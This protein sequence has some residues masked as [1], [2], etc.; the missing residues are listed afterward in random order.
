MRGPRRRLRALALVAVFALVLGACGTDDA[1][2]PDPDQTESPEESPGGEAQEP[3][4]GGTFIYARDQEPGVLNPLINDGNLV[5]TAQIALS[6]MLPLWIITPDFEYV[7]SPLLE[8]AE[9]SGEDEE[10]FSVTY[11]LN[12]D[13]VWSDGE[14]IT[15]GDVFFT[16]EICL[17]EEADITSRE[18]CNKVD[19]QRTEE[20]LDPDSKEFTLYFTEPYAPWQ[21][22]F[23]TASGIILPQH[24]LENNR[25]E[26]FNTTWSDAIDNPETGEPIA[27]GPFIFDEWRRGQQLSLVRNESYEQYAGRNAYLDRIVYRFIPDFDTMVQ[28]L[29]GG[30]VDA[31]NPQPQLDLVQQIEEMD[32][33]V[34]DIDAGPVWEHI[35]F[36]GTHP[37]LSNEYVRRAI[38]MSIDRQ[39]FVDEFIA[40]IY[41]ESE[42]LNSIVY[43]GNQPEY[44]DHYGDVIEYDPEG[45][46]QLLEDNGCERGDDDIY[47][48]D[49]E[50]LSFDWTTTA[51]NERRELFFEFAQQ[52]LQ[53]NGIEVNADFGEAAV[54]FS[55]DVIV[56]GAWDI[57]NFAWAGSPDPA[58]NVQLWGCFDDPEQPTEGAVPDDPT[59]KEQVDEIRGAQN[60][61][62]TCPPV[63]VSN[64]LLDTNTAVD[65][66]ERASLMNEAGDQLAEIVPILPLYQLPEV[67]AWRDTFTG[68]RVNATQWGPVW[69]VAEWGVVAGEEV[70]EEREPEAGTSPGESPGADESPSPS[71]SPEATEEEA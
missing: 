48:C 42:P 31:M 71:P 34:L 2:Q 39:Q 46:Q 13:A 5:A 58:S 50:R 29:R 26:A 14:Q 45:A 33:V 67:L 61:H 56:A 41:E 40:P 68:L 52:E 4:E 6:T 60:Y 16:L 15:A 11:N 10:D 53:Q 28:Q 17:D 18:G 70:P 62:R 24:A 21:T 43:V 49:G 55:A 37:A 22:M 25:G 9:A 23:S 19:M 51:G 44:E 36:Q 47:V 8:S 35:D 1:E 32:N 66:E 65:P 27:S 3:Q 59:N 63:E 57:F 64:T 12:P 30:E 20:E 54:V 69:N 7:E 38:A